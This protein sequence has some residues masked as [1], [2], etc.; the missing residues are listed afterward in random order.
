[1]KSALTIAAVLLT[2]APSAADAQGQPAR[3]DTTALATQ[4]ARLRARDPFRLDRKP[5]AVRYNPWETVTAPVAT[6]PR[7][8]PPLA[9]AGLVGGPPWNALIEGVPGAEGG[10]L[11]TLGDS[12]KG[13]LFTALRG[14]TV[15]LVGFDTTWSLT[16][17]RPWR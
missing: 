5:A 2:A 1:M 9:L 11:L 15:F 14:D 7:A 4:A 8:L 10:F 6:P 16:P 12:A 13:I 3:A 17:R